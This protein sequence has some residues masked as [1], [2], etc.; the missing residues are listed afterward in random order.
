MK[1]ILLLLIFLILGTNIASAQQNTQ[2]TFPIAELG[3]CN[4]IQTCKV[5]C[6]Q[7]ENH[8]SCIAFAKSKGLY[9][10]TVNEKKANALALAK[11][12]LGCTSFQSCKAF[13]EQAENKAKC[14]SF[15][16]KH[17]LV[18]THSA[19]DEKLL[20]KAKQ[21]LNCSSA[22][23][24]KVLCDKQENYTK[25]AA[26]LQDQVTSDER[27]MFEKY[28]PLIK[29][30]LG[31]DSI[32]ICMAFCIN[33]L[34]TNKCQELAERIEVEQ[35]GTHSSDSSEPPEVWCPKVSSE[36]KWDGTTCV[37][38]GPETCV[39]A[40]DIPGCTWD[41]AQ[42]N[43]P[44]T[45]TEEPG[46]VWC[47]KAG[48]NCSW[49]GKQC[50]CL[51]SGSNE[52]PY[53]TQ[54]PGE[55]RCPKIGP[56]CVWDGS[57]CTCWDECVKAGGKWTGKVCEYQGGTTAPT[58]EP[59]EVWCPKNPGCKWTGETCLCEPVLVPQTPEPSSS[60]AVQG[61][62]TNRGLLFQILDFLLK[63]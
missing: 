52:V 10:E 15:A 48:P 44:G 13:C 23:E 58:T 2:I 8:E 53:P 50:L 11:G 28:K 46:E 38:M 30:Y 7:R 19:K 26:L 27:A 1:N 56:Y 51:G 21:N 5:Y 3:N 29:E 59:G 17:A 45:K 60:P 31:C 57:S 4:N 54:E 49:D 61:I 9:K 25:C 22:E 36:C 40:N 55:V 47:P 42:C 34:N 43:C 33:P 18:T 32:V 6:D 12:E 41:G 37:C 39:K 20:E 16:Q 62:T 35:G 14:Q 63:K 24:C